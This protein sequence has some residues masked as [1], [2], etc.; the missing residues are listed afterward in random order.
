MS[1][2]E[3]GAQNKRAMAKKYSV[4]AHV[5]AMVSIIRPGVGWWLDAHNHRFGHKGLLGVLVSLPQISKSRCRIRGTITENKKKT[6]STPFVGLMSKPIRRESCGC[7]TGSSDLRDGPGSGMRVLLGR[8]GANMEGKRGRKE[9]AK[10]EAVGRT[11]LDFGG[12]GYS[13]EWSSK[14]R[15]GV[16]PRC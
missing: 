14:R 12:A 15:R 6:K 2:A 5:A 13:L 3:D 7:V 4:R 10:R 11:P 16:D 8:S 1:L 9:V